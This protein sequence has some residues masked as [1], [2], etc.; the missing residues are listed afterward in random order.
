MHLFEWSWEDVAKDSWVEKFFKFRF[1][2][3]NRLFLGFHGFFLH[4]CVF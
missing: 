3:V 4:V 1:V 2:C